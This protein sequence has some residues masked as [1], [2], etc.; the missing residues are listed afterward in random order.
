MGYYLKRTG[1]DLPNHTPGMALFFGTL[2][3]LAGAGLV[4]AVYGYA[5]LEL[6]KLPRWLDVI[7]TALLLKPLFA[8]RLLLKE[9][10]AVEA[11]L[12]QGLDGGRSRLAHIVS[13]DTT[14]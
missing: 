1:R 9:V 8:L 12:A 6:A 2:A 14:H 13:R 4:A 10:T 5:G 11:A 7:L 3:W